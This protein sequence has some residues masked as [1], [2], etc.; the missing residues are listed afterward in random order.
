[1]AVAVITGAAG[2]IGSAAAARFA[3]LCLEVFGMEN[4]MRACFFF[5]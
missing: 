4:D 3:C 2:L 1:M 5:I